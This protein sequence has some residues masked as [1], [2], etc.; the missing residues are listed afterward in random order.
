MFEKPNLFWVIET[1]GELG[2]TL[3]VSP[4]NHQSSKHQSFICYKY[5]IPAI[6]D[7]L[8]EAAQD[9]HTK[10]KKKNN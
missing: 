8:E 1:C 6:E 5:F 4:A 9:G 7:Y 3:L 10:L 2:G